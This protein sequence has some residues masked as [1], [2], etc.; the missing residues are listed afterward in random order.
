[1]N[2]SSK[3]LVYGGAVAG[4]AMLLGAGLIIG[5]GIAK[6]DAY[7]ELGPVVCQALESGRMTASQLEAL[8]MQAT[9]EIPGPKGP[10][11]H[12]QATQ[13]ITVLVSAYCPSQLVN[14]AS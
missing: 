12:E 10:L 9:R 5:A 4:G 2:A 13:V 11:N 14:I 6:A 7:T 1:M 8:V 3:K